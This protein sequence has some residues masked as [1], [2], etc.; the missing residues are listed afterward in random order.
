M[1]TQ[2]SEKP[3]SLVRQPQAP[4]KSMR[5]PNVAM[6]TIIE[7]ETSKYYKE[8]SNSNMRY[9]DSELLSPTKRLIPSPKKNS[10]SNG[11]QF[12]FELKVNPPSNT[13]VD[14]ENQSQ[15][16]SH[17]QSVHSE[18]VAAKAMGI[19]LSSSK[20]EKYEGD[21][22]KDIYEP[23]PEFEGASV[24]EANANSSFHHYE[25]ISSRDYSMNRFDS[26]EIPNDGRKYL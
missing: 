19:K 8:D 12:N 15:N 21:S 14:N 10:T 6:E 18:N 13:S 25:D 20:L 9:R 4:R 23:L 2:E 7:N 1:K 24:N 11:S 5:L 16:S 17:Q 22:R 26:Y 3:S